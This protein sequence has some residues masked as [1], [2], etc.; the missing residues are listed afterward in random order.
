MIFLNQGVSVAVVGQNS[1]VKFVG[2]E[3]PVEIFNKHFDT[4]QNIDYWHN[5]RYL[6]SDYAEKLV[7]QIFAS[8]KK[9]Y[10]LYLKSEEHKII[11]DYGLPFLDKTKSRNLQN[12]EDIM[13]YVFNSRF[14]ATDIVK[15]EFNK[16]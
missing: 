1:N 6:K 3:M 11:L 9:V 8:D 14:W 4:L 13:F 10:V 12:C 15:C 7:S 2:S 5:S 16:K